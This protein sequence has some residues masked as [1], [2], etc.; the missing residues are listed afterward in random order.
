M[1]SVGRSLGRS[2]QGRGAF[3]R[4]KDVLHEDFP[5]LLPIW[6]AFSDVRATRRAV[7]WLV[8]NSLVERDAATSLLTEYEDPDLP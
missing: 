5:Q 6:Y 1:I 3:R 8:D 7:E 2:I 4:F